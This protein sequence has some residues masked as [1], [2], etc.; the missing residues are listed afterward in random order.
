MSGSVRYGSELDT[1]ALDQTADQL[2]FAQTAIGAPLPAQ[3]VTFTNIGTVPATLGQAALT[4]PAPGDFDVAADNCSAQ[5][6]AVGDSCAVTVEFLPIARGQRRAY[7]SIPD[8]T[9]RGGRTVMVQGYGLQPTV[10]ELTAPTVPQFGPAPATIDVTVYPAA[11]GYPNLYL[12]GVQMF[13]PV[14]SVL[15]SPSRLRLRYTVTLT[16]GHH[17]MA[18][19]FEG[20]DFFTDA[21]PTSLDVVVGIKTD[22]SLSTA[23]D[24]GVAAGE[25]ADLVAQLRTGASLTGGTLEIRDGTTHELLASAAVS[26]S[27]P[28]LVHTVTPGLGSDPF[29]AAFIPASAGVQAATAVTDVVVV[30]GPRPETVM[31]STPLLTSSFTVQSA[32]SSP[33]VGVTFQ[34][35][36]DASD[37]FSCE[38]PYTFYQNNPG[39]YLIIVRAHRA[40]GLS[41]RTPATRAWT[42]DLRSVSIDGGA[43]Y[44]TTPS[45]TVSLPAAID[46]PGVAQVALSNDGTSWTTRAY[47]PSQNWTL[48]PLNGVKTV[49]VKL[50]D[51]GGNW[52]PARTD[53]IVLDGS[54]PT[55]T[56][57]RNAFVATSIV[58]SGKPNVRLAWSGADATSGVDRYQLAQSS[59]GGPYAM[60]STTPTPSL[61]RAL[62]PG[63]AYRFRVR[64]IDHAG[65]V[66]S[67][68]YGTSFLESAAQESSSRITWSR[69]WRVGSSPSYWGGRARFA[70]AA[71]A[72]ATIKV[73]GRS[74]AWVASTGPTRGSARI[75]VNG[76]LVKTVSLYATTSSARQVVFATSW[77][78]LATRT[79]VI[80][81]VGTAG[82]ARVDLDTLVWAT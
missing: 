46:S 63:H 77:S 37:W 54:A 11:T 24:D 18:A 3:T 56:G 70:T 62:A 58:G 48:T 72:K 35:R 78:T 73:T 15:T 8:G 10:V 45:V 81:V 65:N 12:D 22:L 36:Y 1:V 17:H 34:C 23:T 39:T 38:S 67:W 52:S 14:D 30:S 60:V 44:T 51:A 68:A 40:N 29:E 64:A 69:T 4:G 28:S 47:A 25:S 27:N 26:G 74:F 6:V 80:R 71:G 42:I 13:G 55:A 57:P 32:F 49:W 7:L 43:P 66:G 20:L 75:Y 59:D 76:V 41:D 61:T 31:D 50:S 19:T 2:L 33:D 5:T 53:T 21:T 82:H 16:P 79:I 9:A